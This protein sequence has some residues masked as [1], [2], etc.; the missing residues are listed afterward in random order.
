MLTATSGTT[1]TWQ[2]NTPSVPVPVSQGGIG[3]S[4]LTAYALLAG[5]TATTS[6]VQSLAA[7]I[8]GQVL[9]SGGAGVLPAWQ[10]GSA[11]TA[12]YLADLTGTVYVASAAAPSAGQVLTAVN[13][14]TA[15]WQNATG[16]GSGVQIGGDLGG[17]TAA[18][19]VISTHFPVVT[20]SSAAGTV[21]LNPVSTR[22]FNVTQSGDCVF[23]FNPTPAFGSGTAYSFELWLYQNAAGTHATTFPATVTWL[24]GGTVTPVLNTAG[25]AL[26]LLTFETINAGTAWA[27]AL[28]E[29]PSLPLTVING[30]TGLFEAGSAGTFFT[31]QGLTTPG[32]WT[33]LVPLNTV[34]SS[35]F[36]ATLGMLNPV[37]ASAGPGTATLPGGQ[38]AGQLAGVKMT[39]TAS[40]N[41]VLIQPTL[42][43]VMGR[44]YGWNISGGAYGSQSTLSL[45]NQGQLLTYNPAGPAW[46]ATYTASNA[47]GSI[48]VG[49]SPAP[50]V[51]GQLVYLT[52]GSAPSG[53]NLNIPYYVVET[54]GP[55]SE[56]F[57]Y[58]I[59]TTSTGGAVA[60]ISTGSGVFVQTC[61]NWTTLAD[62]LP[63]S[64]LETLF[65][66]AG[67]AGYL[68]PPT[69]YGPASQ[70]VLATSLAPLSAVSSANINT[71]SFT[72]PASGSVIVTVSLTYENT[73][74]STFN[75][76]GLGL[77]GGTVPVCPN[78][79][80]EYLSGGKPIQQQ[81]MFLVAGLSGAT[82]LDLLFGTSADTLNVYAY[83]NSGG[84]AGNTPG[85]P[86]IMTVQGS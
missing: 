14:G 45:S 76:F 82:T 34:E 50:F 85:S 10:A 69:S 78:N 72:A 47:H 81:M 40:S 13:A 46:A 32:A 5:G 53:L 30:G 19:Q 74:T 44:T 2:A 68:C 59:S 60:P 24:S 86:V 3:G 4:V 29:A 48:N 66:P 55:T 22:V 17:G 73:Q 11:S 77:H 6:P 65:A 36:T 63:L 28:A 7:G 71:G 80:S 20:N 18:P 38:F 21:N 54:T 57:T 25:S 37:D 16:G 9:V 51:D 61:G 26:S 12:G 41:T 75:T 58:E 56:A 1:A 62:D 52:A 70:T 49:D 84:T 83:G 23:T 33:G 43:D 64:Q 31:S 79:T 35:G 27:G 42:P 8:S 67:A 15:S 39:N